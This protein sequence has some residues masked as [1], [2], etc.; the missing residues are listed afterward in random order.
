MIASLALVLAAKPVALAYC[1]RYYAAGA[2]KSWFRVYVCDESGGGRKVVSTST[3]NA[4]QVMW[5]GSNRLVWIEDA[6][7]D[8]PT[9]WTATLGTKAKKLRT[10]TSGDVGERKWMTVAP[11]TAALTSDNGTVYVGA[12]GKVSRGPAP[13]AP[14]NRLLPTFADNGEWEFKGAGDYTLVARQTDDGAS[15]KAVSLDGISTVW[16]SDEDRLAQ[17]MTAKD[18]KTAFVLTFSHDST[19]GSHFGLVRVD[20]L[21]GKSAS[22]FENASNADYWPS[23]TTFAWTDGRELSPVASKQLWTNSLW[24]AD[25]QAGWRKRVV[26]GPVWVLDGMLRP[27][28]SFN[29]PSGG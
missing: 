11:G 21:T 9:L 15:V 26:T 6:N 20:L 8:Q 27:G 29:R 23:R 13:V 17:L 19:T 5:A 4:S 10:L 22:V 1:A 25:S 18:G 3:R 16:S 14:V 28:A 12:D 2:A 24:I 7:G